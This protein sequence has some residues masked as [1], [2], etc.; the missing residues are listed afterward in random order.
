[1]TVW[2]PLP[3]DA[4]VRTACLEWVVSG[5]WTARGGH[6]YKVTSP[7]GLTTGDAPSLVQVELV[8]DA[9]APGQARRVTRQALAIGAYLLW[10]TG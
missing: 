4:F 2:L 9:G 1:M 6:G 8:Q 3:A 7:D 5:C 10:S